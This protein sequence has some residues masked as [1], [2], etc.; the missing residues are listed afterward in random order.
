M[1]KGWPLAMDKDCRK[2]NERQ[3]T[4]MKG[5]NDCNKVLYNRAGPPLKWQSAAHDY[6][7]V[8]QAGHCYDPDPKGGDSAYHRVQ[9]DT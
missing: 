3:K 6:H 7:L 2:M 9:H 1:L 4:T 5:D 8:C